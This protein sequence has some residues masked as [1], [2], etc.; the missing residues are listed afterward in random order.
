[1]YFQRC[2]LHKFII[3]LYSHLFIMQKCYITSKNQ[4]YAV[5]NARIV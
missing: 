1:M 4:K 3:N 2:P 5:N